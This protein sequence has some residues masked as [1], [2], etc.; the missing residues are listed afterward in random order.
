M[1]RFWSQSECSLIILVLEMKSQ[2]DSKSSY[3]KETWL[4]VIAP[5][6]I[7]IKPEPNM[8]YIYLIVEA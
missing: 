5:A 2:F 3:G 8:K 1:C 4:L 7:L 6:P